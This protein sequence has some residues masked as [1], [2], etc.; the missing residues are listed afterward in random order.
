MA[1]TQHA[2]D[3]AKA[4]GRERGLSGAP[5]TAN[6]HTGA[7]GTDKR[8]LGVAWLTGWES[9]RARRLEDNAQQPNLPAG[10]S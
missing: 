7:L 2:A 3:T 6:P 9:G 1:L 8:A 10:Y 4:Q 5:A